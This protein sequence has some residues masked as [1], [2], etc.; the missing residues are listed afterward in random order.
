MKVK[1]DKDLCVGCGTCAA[2]APDLFEMT[3]DGKAIFIGELNEETMETTDR[4]ISMCPTAAIIKSEEEQNL[5]F[6]DQNSK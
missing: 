3:D 6:K 5:K 1:V 2:V 4:A